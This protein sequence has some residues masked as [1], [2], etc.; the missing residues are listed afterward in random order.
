MALSNDHGFVNKPYATRKLRRGPDGTQQ[1][2]FVDVRTGKEI[3]NP[4]GYNLIEDTNTLQDLPK[5]ETTKN[6][7]QETKPQEV[8]QSSRSDHM[9]DGQPDYKSQTNPQYYNKPAAL[10]FTNY[11]PG[12]FGMLGKLA[13]TAVNA[14]NFGATSAARESL[15][16]SKPTV[17]NTVKSLARDQHGYVGDISLPNATGGQD[18]VPVGFEASDKT[19][20]TT[21]TPQEALARQGAISRASGVTPGE[22]T[23][24][25]VKTARED[26]KEKY[27]GHTGFL[28]K[29][30]SAAKEL[31]SGVGDAVKDTVQNT[32]DWMD[33]K[34]AEDTYYSKD[35]FPEA[36]KKDES[37]SDTTSNSG[38]SGN[39]DFSGSGQFNDSQSKGGVGL[40]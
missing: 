1:V 23:P 20:R 16:F 2:Y 11:L 39:S 13:N 19:G 25:Q 17:G 24:E 28:T 34:K 9:P 38:N 33:Q 40:Y 3:T 7:S 37:T 32:T 29:L 18:S 5:V 36:P 15:G 12:A 21:M 27:G 8:R 14:N 6:I 10:G 30:A 26:Y 35:Y 22:S 31:F 4:S